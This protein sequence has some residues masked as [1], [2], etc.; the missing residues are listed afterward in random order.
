MKKL[1][2]FLIMLFTSF[3]TFAMVNPASENCT[4]SWGT[5]KIEKIWDWSEIGVCYFDDNKQCEEWALYRNECPLGWVKITGYITEAAR[6]CAIIGWDFKES[7]TG[8]NEDY[9]NQPWTCTL[10]NWNA[11]DVWNLYNNVIDTNSVDTNCNGSGDS[12]ENC[13]ATV[14]ETSEQSCGSFWNLLAEK[15]MKLADDFIVKFQAKTS[16]LSQEKIIAK[17]S[18][19]NNA[20]DKLIEKYK[21]KTNAKYV[22]IVNLLKYIKC[23]A[24]KAFLIDDSEVSIESDWNIQTLSIS[25]LEEIDEWEKSIIKYDS[26]YILIDVQYPKT[27]LTKIDETIKAFVYDEIEN[28]IKNLPQEKPYVEW[29][30]YSF[31]IDYDFEIINDKY[32]TIKFNLSSFCWWAHPSPYIKT[33]NFEKESE[34]NITLQAYLSWKNDY[35]NQLSTISYGKLIKN[36]N[37]KEMNDFE[38]V[39]QW[40]AATGTNF[41]FFNIMDNGLIVYFPAYQVW[42]YALWE[43]SVEIKLEEFN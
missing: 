4:N 42:P 35:L 38:R 32:I 16:K 15:N 41:Q 25:D 20:I 12:S 33:F 26:G 22:E 30:Q 13:L 17:N 3:S 43:Q 31:Y 11:V 24:S 6:Y 19:L 5:L 40:T 7:P 34:K 21:N 23:M 37:I 27:D 10:P 18:K 14:S 29:M 8:D 36:E 9:S 1:L 2:F 28:F 39:K